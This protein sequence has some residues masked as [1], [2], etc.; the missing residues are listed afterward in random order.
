MFYDIIQKMKLSP[1][2]LILTAL[3]TLLACTS[4]N[5]NQG[6][7]GGSVYFRETGFTVSGP[8]LELYNS[9][10]DPLLI[11]GFPI[12]EVVEHPILP[13][14]QVQYFQRARMEFDGT[15][16]DGQQVTLAELGNY[17]YDDENNGDDAN[18]YTN[19]A[20]CRMF[21]T[22]F[23]VCYAFLQFYDAHDGEKFFGNPISEVRVIDGRVV[24]Y[25]ERTRIEW[26]PENIPGRRVKLTDLGQVDCEKN[27]PAADNIGRIGQFNY[28]VRV[29]PAK[30]LIGPNETQTIFVIVQDEQYRPYPGAQVAV[31]LQYPDGHEIQQRLVNTDEYG[32]TTL[33]NISTA[34]VKPNQFVKVTVEMKTSFDQ[35]SILT[36]IWFR[37]WW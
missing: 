21:P 29:F 25:F 37:V 22:G 13:G 19:N 1:R 16:P 10:D 8:F 7:T 31:K 32:I 33:D 5:S 34:G 26:R 6:S 12:S 35:P 14:I 20:A 30:P 36:T 2:W 24:Q 27:C 18:I 17:Y 9:A 4:G 23:P 28:R 3:L 15:K 11:F